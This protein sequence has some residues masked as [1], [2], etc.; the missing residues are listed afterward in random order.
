M[1]FGD[2]YETPDG[3]CIRD[4]IHVTDLAQA[5]ILGAKYILENNKSLLVNLG[6]N[7]GYSVMEV[8]KEVEKLSP[9]HYEMCERRAG[10]TAKLID[11]YTKAKE[12]LGWEPKYKLFEIVKSDYDFRAKI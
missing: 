12:I 4:Y 9:V 1:V 2:D 5:H 7:E 10:D 6:S 8:I 3:T 11:S